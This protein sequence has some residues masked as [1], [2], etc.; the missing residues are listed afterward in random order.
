MSLF[1]DPLSL[2]SFFP[3]STTSSSVSPSPI[4]SSFPLFY[5]RKPSL[6]LLT[7]VISVPLRQNVVVTEPSTV[8]LLYVQ[9]ARVMLQHMGK[10]ASMLEMP[11]MRNTLEYHDV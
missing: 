1:Q 3:F 5:S 9:L 11:R 2:P 8:G 10:R 6:S 4:P 7:S